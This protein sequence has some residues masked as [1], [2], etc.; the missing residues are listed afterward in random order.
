MQRISSE[1]AGF[2]RD[3][4]VRAFDLLSERTTELPAPLRPMVRAW[5][6][7]SATQKNNL[8]DELISLVRGTAVEKPAAKKAR[9][10]KKSAP[11]KTKS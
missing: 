9:P 3:T 11:K 7:L 8:F 10:R 2:V 1:F 6:K 4:G 5:N